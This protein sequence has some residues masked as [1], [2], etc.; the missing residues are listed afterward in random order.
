MELYQVR[1]FVTVAR[2]G[3]VTKALSVTQPAITA[4]LKQA[5]WK[6]SVFDQT[7]VAC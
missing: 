3:V 6:S 7:W 4:Q 2:L 5:C 1:A